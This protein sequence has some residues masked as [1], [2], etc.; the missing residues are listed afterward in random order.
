VAAEEVES[1]LLA[2]ASLI[3]ET[4][5]ALYEPDLGRVRERLR[6]ELER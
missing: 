5:A 1:A 3:E 2:A 6:A 4:G